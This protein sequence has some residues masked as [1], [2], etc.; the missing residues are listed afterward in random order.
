MNQKRAVH[1]GIKVQP[2]V[3]TFSSQIFGHETRCL[4]LISHLQ[5]VTDPSELSRRLFLDVSDEMDTQGLS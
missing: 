3:W 4:T 2:V 5:A 1:I